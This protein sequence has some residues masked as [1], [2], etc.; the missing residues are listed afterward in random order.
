MTWCN[1]GNLLHT[2][3]SHQPDPEAGGELG[4]VL[5]RAKC[6]LSDVWS[7]RLICTIRGSLEENKS[8]VVVVSYSPAWWSWS[9][10][11]GW[12]TWWRGGWSLFWYMLSKSEAWV[13]LLSVCFPLSSA[14]AW[15]GFPRRSQ[16]RW[17]I[18]RVCVGYNSIPLFNKQLMKN[19][20][21]NN[22]SL[23]RCLFQSDLLT[24]F[25]HLK[26]FLFSGFMPEKF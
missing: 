23:K 3:E 1:S 20:W 5:H 18:P 19:E 26:S 8:S 14:P 6:W 12:G 10:S 15:G 4:L 13:H 21:G 24:G 2:L 25:S 17:V 7:G 11:L 9:S 22:R 16:I